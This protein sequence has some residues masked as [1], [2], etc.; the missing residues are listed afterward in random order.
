MALTATHESRV[1]VRNVYFLKERKNLSDE[2]IMRELN[3]SQQL[4]QEAKLVIKHGF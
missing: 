2:E 3:I 4:P 1:L